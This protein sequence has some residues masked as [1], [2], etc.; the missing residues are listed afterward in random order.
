[1][2]PN[3]PNVVP[4]EAYQ[5]LA[6]VVQALQHQ[7]GQMQTT[8]QQL[9][10]QLEQQQQQPP[11]A[12]VTVPV[13]PAAPSPLAFVQPTKPDTFNGDKRTKAD[14]WLF[15]LENY[16]AATNLQDPHRVPFAVSQFR[17]AAVT[18]WKHYT[19]AIGNA[20]PP[21]PVRTTWEAFKTVFLDTYRPIEASE[22]A[23]AALH[24]IRQTGSVA[25]YI[26]VF[27]KHLNYVDNMAMEDQ[28]FLFKKGLSYQLAKEI[29]MHHPKTLTEAMNYAQR[30]EVE[31]RML[32]GSRHNTS[33]A[34][35]KG[36]AGQFQH[37]RRN[38]HF[39]HQ[40]RTFFAQPNQIS[41]S[42]SAVP[43]ELGKMEEQAN[44]EMVHGYEETNDNEAN[45]GYQHE[46]L[47]AVFS[48]NKSNVAVRTNRTFVPG[49]SRQ[50]F[51]RCYKAGLCL[52]CKQRGHVARN[53]PNQSS[54][55]TNNATSKNH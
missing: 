44:E 39:G 42:Q 29:G 8:Q 35:G 3:Q 20:D 46:H 27:L 31:N 47:N 52:V 51:E 32:Q 1:M 5:Q 16:F 34:P 53:C 45:D 23:R 10:Q 37:G 54:R 7:L 55:P 33:S 41:I 13:V 6:N 26:D 17:D 30:A 50:E 15:E 43:M 24:A 40:G 38:N 21:S 18:W 11:Q 9:Q 36:N 12:A 28:I 19:D 14:V 2:D 49:V 48:G 25:G 4:V 22:T